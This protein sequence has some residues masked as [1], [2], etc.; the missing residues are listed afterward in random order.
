MTIQMSGDVRGWF[1]ERLT[2][3]LDEQRISASETTQLYLVELLASHAE[4][5]LDPRLER[6]LAL[7]LGDAAEAAG[8]EKIRIL[9]RLGDTALYILGFFE[10]HLEHRGVSRSYVV[11][12]GGH[13]YSNAGALAAFSPTEGVRREVYGEL[14]DGFEGY[15][16]ALDEV[17]ESTA[18]R[19]PQDI[20]RLYEKWKRTRSPRLA[21]RLQQEGVFPTVGASDEEDGSELLH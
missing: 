4:R 1:H 2:R 6:P 20:V 17:R 19:T 15:V 5:P 13:A 18:L 14:A 11:Q 8:A 16:S 3:A 21:A 12:M 9:R 7:Q 10:D